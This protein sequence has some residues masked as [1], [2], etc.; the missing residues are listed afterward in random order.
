MFCLLLL[1]MHQ[2]EDANLIPSG[3]LLLTYVLPMDWPQKTPC[4]RIRGLKSVPGVPDHLKSHA[5][6]DCIIMSSELRLY[7]LDNR[8]EAAVESCPPVPVGVATS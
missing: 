1:R 2:T 7:V 4:S 5:V 3:A 8:V 6:I